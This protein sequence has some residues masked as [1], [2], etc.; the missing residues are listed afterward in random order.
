MVR[1]FAVYPHGDFDWLN[2]DE[3]VFEEYGVHY[4]WYAVETGNLCPAGWRV[5]GIDDWTMESVSSE[6]P[7]NQPDF[8]YVA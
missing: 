1:A 3:E 5:P 4:N 2:S 7:T 6:S 8:R